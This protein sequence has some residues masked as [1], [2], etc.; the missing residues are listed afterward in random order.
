MSDLEIKSFYN[1]EYDY[2]LV[3]LELSKLKYPESYSAVAE[4]GERFRDH[5][6]RSGNIDDLPPIPKP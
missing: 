2:L 3:Q 1:R 5:I 6:K 4:L